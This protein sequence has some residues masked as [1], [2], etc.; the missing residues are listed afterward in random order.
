MNDQEL[1]NYIMTE[2]VNSGFITVHQWRNFV[3]YLWIFEKKA[4]D[5]LLKDEIRFLDYIERQ[6]I[7]SG[8]KVYTSWLK[9]EVTRRKQQ[10]N[11]SQKE[12]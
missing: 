6:I 7:S 4:K 9:D 2:F 5:E 10:L 8:E 3:D 12:Q 1:R 11:S